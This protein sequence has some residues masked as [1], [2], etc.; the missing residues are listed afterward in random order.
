MTCPHGRSGL[1]CPGPIRVQKSARASGAAVTPISCPNPPPTTSRA[2]ISL[3]NHQI[4]WVTQAF[5]LFRR[6]SASVM[7]R[8]LIPTA[9]DCLRTAL[10]IPSNRAALIRF[11]P[12]SGPDECKMSSCAPSHGREGTNRRRCCMLLHRVRVRRSESC[13][14]ACVC[15]MRAHAPRKNPAVLS[16]AWP[17]IHAATT[18]T[19]S[20]ERARYHL[21]AS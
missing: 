10:Y 5:L 13:L 19:F 1:I 18:L 2:R 20:H 21:V 7:H 16:L 11:A 3:L 9:C 14:R 8:H 17:H 12:V 6:A 4:L 15:M